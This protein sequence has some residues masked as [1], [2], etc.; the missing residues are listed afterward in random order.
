MC[1]HVHSLDE[2]ISAVAGRTEQT[3]DQVASRVRATFIS[4][5][6]SHYVERVPPCFLPPPF[7]RPHENSVKG[8]RGAAAKAGVYAL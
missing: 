7:V 2:L 3:L 6:Q 4:L 8:R 5:V 1:F